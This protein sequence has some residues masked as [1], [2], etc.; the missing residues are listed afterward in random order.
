MNR[1]YT[2]NSKIVTIP[3]HF[4]QKNVSYWFFIFFRLLRSFRSLFVVDN[5]SGVIRARSVYDYTSC[6]DV[7]QRWRGKHG[8][9]SIGMTHLKSYW[10]CVPALAVFG[11]LLGFNELFIFELR[12]FAFELTLNKYYCLLNRSPEHCRL[13]E[14]LFANKTHYKCAKSVFRVFF[15]ITPCRAGWKRNR[16]CGL[17]CVYLDSNIYINVIRCVTR[18]C[19]Y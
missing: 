11:P 7:S 13:W 1:R 17:Q 15:S 5:V 19:R 2:L 10:W 9:R 8:L 18:A 12:V 3:Q 14:N 6:I 16:S 4:W